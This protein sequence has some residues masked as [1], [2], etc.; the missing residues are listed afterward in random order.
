[1]SSERSSRVSA[2]NYI[3]DCGK[4][5]KDVHLLV[6]EKSRTKVLY[7]LPIS[8]RFGLLIASNE[9]VMYFLLGFKIYS[10]RYRIVDVIT[11]NGSMLRLKEGKVML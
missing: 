6:F 7:L 8:G 9:V 5:G 4:E 10:I 2:N 1:M 11:L 3:C